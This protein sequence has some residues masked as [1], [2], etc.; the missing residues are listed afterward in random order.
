[1][2]GESKD[3]RDK[4]SKDGLWLKSYTWCGVSGK[5]RAG[6]LWN[7]LETRTMGQH[8]DACYSEAVNGF[9]G[10]QEFAEW[11]QHQAGYLNKD[12][13]G[14]FWQLDKD[15]LGNGKL[16]SPTTCV[17]IPGKLNSLLIEQ[18]SKS[19]LMLGVT[20]DLN[21]SPRFVSRGRLFSGKKQHIGTF[22]TE[23]EAHTAY[24][25][26]KREVIFMA[27]RQMTLPVQVVQALVSRWDV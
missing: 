10:F 11:C 18:P 23:I 7:N 3:Y 5:T 2:A 16:Y 12:P 19:G 22:D 15:I 26:F 8:P 13:D 17:F 21:N 6:K 27:I 20:Q 4:K 24:I 14:K 1:M 9:S 25:N